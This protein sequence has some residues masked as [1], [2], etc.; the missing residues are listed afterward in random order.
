MVLRE[1]LAQHD[2][3]QGITNKCRDFD[4]YEPEARCERSQGLSAQ[5]HEGTTIP[6]KITLDAYA[7]SHRAVADLK[8]RCERQVSN[9]PAS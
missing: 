1:A 6:I 8:D 7:A 5:G 9:N 2:R 4:F 3:G